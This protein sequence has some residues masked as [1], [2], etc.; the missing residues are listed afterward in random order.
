MKISSLFIICLLLVSSENIAQKSNNSG[1]ALLDVGMNFKFDSPKALGGGIA[2][3]LAVGQ[4][5]KNQVFAGISFNATHFKDSKYPDDKFGFLIQSRVRH[6]LLSADLHIGKSWIIS[7]TGNQMQLAAGLGAM[8]YEQP[9][10]FNNPNPNCI[11][12][13][14]S[15]KYDYKNYYATVLPLTAR[16]VAHSPIGAVGV[17]LKYYVNSLLSYGSLTLCY[18]AASKLKKL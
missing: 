6:H 10:F 1:F 5:F 18:G 8:K 11:L 2:A 3:G 14:N 13:C 4:L 9:Y 12:F 16:F 15:L 17:T 7:Q